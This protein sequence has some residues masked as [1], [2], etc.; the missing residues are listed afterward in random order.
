ML[1]KHYATTHNVSRIDDIID[2]YSEPQNISCLSEIFSFLKKYFARLA[3]TRFIFDV[4][5]FLKETCLI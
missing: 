4:D 3:D 5:V 1:K 2:G